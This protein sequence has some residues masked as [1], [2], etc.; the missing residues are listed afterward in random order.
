MF[1]WSHNKRLAGRPSLSLCCCEHPKPLNKWSCTR[2]ETRIDKQNQDKTYSWRSYLEDEDTT[3]TSTERPSEYHTDEEPERPHT[4]ITNPFEPTMVDTPNKDM[5]WKL[6][7]PT[8][9]SGKREDLRKFLQE[10]KIYLMANSD[11]YLDEILGR[12]NFL[13]QPN[14][15]LHRTMRL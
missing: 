12:K 15:L 8:P 4:P 13:I 3:N 1:T 14:R 7:T 2:W 10:I 9:F 6:K 11:A 5:K